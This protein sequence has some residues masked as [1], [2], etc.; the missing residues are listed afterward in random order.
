[1]AIAQAQGLGLHLDTDAPSLDAEAKNIRN[2]VWH[3]L[4]SIE[5]A[6]VLIT[7]RVPLIREVH[8]SAPIPGMP[9]QDDLKTD[10]KGYAVPD[11]YIIC[12]RGLF[13]IIN[14]TVMILYNTQNT[15]MSPPAYQ[16]NVACLEARLAQWKS[17]VPEEL[18]FET[19][20]NAVTDITIDCE[21]GICKDCI[22][23]MPL[24]NIP[25]GN[26]AKIGSCGPL[27]QRSHDHPQTFLV[28]R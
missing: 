1:M 3:A 22:A 24:A 20:P 12:Q 28:P 4:Y 17:Q 25:F 7:G 8:C 14:E 15:Y 9:C 26:V 11:P 19:L 16:E 10:G 21:V 5:A 27:S 2:C 18:S 13:A 23:G 6:L